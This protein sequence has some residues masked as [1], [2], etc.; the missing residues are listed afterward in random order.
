[1]RRTAGFVGAAIAAVGLVIGTA[2]VANAL[3]V[4]LPGTTSHSYVA[5]VDM[6]P[7]TYYSRF[8]GDACQFTLT[9]AGET[10]PSLDGISMSNRYRIVDLDAG[11]RLDSVGCT[12]WHRQGDSFG[13][14][15]SDD[16]GL[17]GMTGS[18]EG[19]VFDNLPLGS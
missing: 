5:G 4:S 18:L 13:S 17:L 11:D 6:E 12:T 14:A 15:G 9:Q 19:F 3:P 10:E 8:T 1:M 7:G 16:L 2:G